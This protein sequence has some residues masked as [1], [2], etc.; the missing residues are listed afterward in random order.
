MADEIDERLRAWVN[1]AHE[2][3]RA[4][5]HAFDHGLHRSSVSRAYYAL[6]QSA[7]AIAL[8]AG[9]SPPAAGNWSHAALP[10]LF[11]TSAVRRIIGRRSIELKQAASRAY[12]DRCDADYRP[13]VRVDKQQSIHNRRLAGMF[14]AKACEVTGYDPR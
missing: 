5:N 6:F 1:A 13:A 8:H 9:L 2:S 12:F 11:E 10:T 3:L 4:A 14:F 7:T